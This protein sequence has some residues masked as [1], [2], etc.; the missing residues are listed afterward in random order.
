MFKIKNLS[1]AKDRVSKSLRSKIV[2]KFT[3]AECNSVYDGETS[4]LL[5]TRVNEHLFTDMNS[6]VYKHL[7]GSSACR[8]V[9]NEQCF[10]ELDSANTTYKPKMKEAL[11]VIWEGPSVN[12][13][14]NHC[15]IS[16]NF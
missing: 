12:E 5:S 1:T 11:H 14:I 9:G 8:E 3:C 6:N 16:V 10:A 4:R 7:E 13:Q 2:Y 15:N